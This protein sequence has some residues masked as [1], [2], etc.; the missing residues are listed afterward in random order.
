MDAV[1]LGSERRDDVPPPLV[2]ADEAA[3][4][5]LDDRLCLALYTASRSMTAV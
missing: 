5:T 3:A 2:T 1:A 4:I